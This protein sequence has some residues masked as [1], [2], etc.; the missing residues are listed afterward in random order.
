MT[1]TEL[2]NEDYRA[3]FYQAQTLTDFIEFLEDHVEN[4]NELHEMFRKQTEAQKALQST[5]Q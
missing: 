5:K 3:Y 1:A 4:L 2:K